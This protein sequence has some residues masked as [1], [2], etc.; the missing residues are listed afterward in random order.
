[1]KTKRFVLLGAALV[2]VAIFSA[3][4]AAQDDPTPNPRWQLGVKAGADAA[5]FSGTQPGLWLSSPDY[6]VTGAMGQHVV[7][8]TGGGYIR[9]Q[10]APRFA[11]QGDVLYAQKGGKGD[12]TGTVLLPS[13]S[14]GAPPQQATINGTMEAHI[15]Y[16]EVPILAMWTAPTSEKTGIGLYG[17]VGLATVVNATA[18]LYGDATTRLGDGSDRKQNFNQTYNIRSEVRDTDL[19][20]IV[21]GNVEWETSHGRIS[22]EARYSSS[23]RTIDQ[24]GEEQVKNSV[25]TMMIGF[26]WGAGSVVDE[27]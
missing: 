25:F 16:V 18:S 13:D 6:Q 8:F 15:D 14:P 21:G 9:F 2:A 22:L 1:M 24:S 4:A 17:G 20:G 12:V 27:K 3:P 19:T 11:L 5:S 7:G 26:A 10:L 23:L